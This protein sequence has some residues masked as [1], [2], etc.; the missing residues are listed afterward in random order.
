ME[1][2]D[3]IG[4]H[5][6]NF[7]M[8]ITEGSESIGDWERVIDCCIRVGLPGLIKEVFEEPCK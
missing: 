6:D 5:V 8:K 4:A 3:G 1:I 7:T 2:F